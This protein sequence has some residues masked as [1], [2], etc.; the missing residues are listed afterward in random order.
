[1]TAAVAASQPNLYS[2]AGKH[3]PWLIAVVVSI[4]TFMEVLDITIAN[5]ALRNI[6]GSLAASFD[7]STWILT[8]YLIANAVILP[9][10]GWLATI[11][12]R[13]RFYMGCVATFTLASFLCGMAWNLSSLIVFRILQGLGGGGLASSEQA[14]LADTF[15]PEKRGQAFAIYGVAV[16]VAPTIGP[17]LGGWITDNASWHWV[18]FINIPMG[19]LSLLLV[20]WLVQEPVATERE[21]Q[22]LLSQGTRIDY[23]GFVLVALGLGCLEVVLDEGERN[24]WF[25]SSFIVTFAI[26][27]AVSLV[28]MV[29]WELR[30][31]APVVDIRLLGERQFG[32]CFLLMLVVGAILIGTTQLVP[33]LLQTQFGY[34]ATL[35]GLALS[36]GGAIMIVMMPVAGLLSGKV[37]PRWLVALGLVITAFAMWYPTRLDGQITLVWAAGIRLLLSL[38]LPFLF[39]P[40]TA[41]SYTGLDQSRT[42]QASALFNV[43]RNLGGSFGVAA[44][45]TLMQQR[46]QFHHTRLIEH[47]TPTVPNFQN[48]LSDLTAYFVAHGSTAAV[49]GHQAIAWMANT[50]D[51]QAALLSFIDVSWVF[52]VTAIVVLPLALVLRPIPLDKSPAAP[53]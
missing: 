5:V 1:M 11:I 32:T 53:S 44:T 50:I 2:S 46:E 20:N 33:Q 4:A 47:I 40:L 52:M 34:T 39:L 14:I 18:F 30:C 35:A 27:S 12:G 21:R 42:S 3:N 22:K 10:S 31:R 38:G 49:A 43:A 45:Q 24:D 29:L 36:P 15:P 51:R 6:A 41:A 19:L 7:Q 8:S 9:L 37:Q 48:A 23:L 13:K 28:A 26:I 17:T 16:V 25:S